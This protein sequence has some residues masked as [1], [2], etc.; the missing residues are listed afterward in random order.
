MKI[1]RGFISNSSSSSF[2]I[3]R[4]CVSD[5][6][7]EKIK[8]HIEESEKTFLV[9]D[10]CYDNHDAWSISDDDYKVEGDTGMDN[11]PMDRFLSEIGI[12]SE[13]IKWRY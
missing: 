11:F 1:R 9:C 6:Q 3:P 12:P 5:Y 4:S 13:K 10:N 7:L 8:N 2:I